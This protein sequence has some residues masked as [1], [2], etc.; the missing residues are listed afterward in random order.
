MRRLNLHTLAFG[1]ASEIE[2]RLSV[3]VEAFTFGGLEYDVDDGCVELSLAASRV[4]SRLTL[5]GR[6]SAQVRGPCQRCLGDAALE[7]AFTCV[8]YVSDGESEGGQDDGYTAGGVLDAERW[9]RD[10]LAE[11]LPERILCHDD[12]RGLCPQCGADLNET[13]P[14]HEHH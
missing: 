6:G 4:A 2:R 12:C 9:V 11:A 7:V 13:G 3:D 1:D 14:G 5:K 10:A 8:E